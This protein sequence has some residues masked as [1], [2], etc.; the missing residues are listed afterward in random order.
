MLVVIA[1]IPPEELCAPPRNRAG[2][3][4]VLSV[5]GVAEGEERGEEEDL[6]ASLWVKF[7]V[8]EG[9]WVCPDTPMLSVTI[10][11]L[12]CASASVY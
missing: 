1:A 12:S 5:S 10:V 11:V 6:G 2:S 8:S 9:N 7:K 3:S 4:S